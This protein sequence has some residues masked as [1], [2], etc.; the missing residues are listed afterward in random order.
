[1]TSP[2]TV[3]PAAPRRVRGGLRERKKDR[4]RRALEEA[5]LE[6]F[7]ERGFD[8]VT[9]DEIAEAAGVSSRTFFRYFGTKEDVVLGPFLELQ[10]VLREALA[11]RPADEPVLEVLRH[12]ID[13]LARRLDALRP[14]IA[15]RVRIVASSRELATRAHQIRDAWRTI[16]L[17]AAARRLGAD[18]ATDL[19]P[20]VA[21][22]WAMAG[23]SAAR[24][25]WERGELRR[26]LTS[27]L[28]EAYELLAGDSL[29]DPAGG[30]PAVARR[31]R[32]APRS[33]AR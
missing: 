26:S 20:H 4:T 28:A 23:L 1:M 19:R 16:L 9:V 22:A 31:A 24:E 27:L 5:A 2:L 13:A 6:L 33:H 14:S 10:A 30:A 8:A 17:E 11:A 21:A 12:G 18:P 15:R 29:G 3:G 32:A 7:G 25:L